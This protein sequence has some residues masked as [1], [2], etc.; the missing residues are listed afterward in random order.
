MVKATRGVLIQCD[1]SIKAI[2]SK[3]DSTH[4]DFIIEDLDDE[5]VVVKESKLQELKEKLREMLR[6]TQMEVDDSGSE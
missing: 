3:I 4:N 2:I 1:P 6:D 5:T